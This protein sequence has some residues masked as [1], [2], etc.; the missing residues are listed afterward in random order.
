ME[1][2]SQSTEPN[3][4]NTQTNKPPC[5]THQGSSLASL[6]SALVRAKSTTAKRACFSM[7]ARS[8]ADSAAS[9]AG[10]ACSLNSLRYCYWLV[11]VG[12]GVEGRL[13]GGVVLSN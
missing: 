13:G 11:W 12:G 4:T 3:H 7:R 10:Q 2:P 6:F 1:G 8:W 5:M 9:R